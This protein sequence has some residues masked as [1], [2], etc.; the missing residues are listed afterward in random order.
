MKKTMVYLPEELHKNLKRL[1]VERDT[2]MADIIRDAAIA[3]LE[4]EIDDI[5][6]A[7]KALREFR[8]EPSSAV[9]LESYH[10]RR[11]R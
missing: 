1:A 11:A 9:P 7:K 8:A 5:N 2:S 3:V 10:R 6:D 4:E